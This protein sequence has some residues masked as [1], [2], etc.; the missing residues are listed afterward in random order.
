MIPSP[1]PPKN[2]KL[3]L[4]NIISGNVIA[5]KLQRRKALFTSCLENIVPSVVDCISIEIEE[6]KKYINVIPDKY[7]TKLGALRIF[8]CSLI[9]SLLLQDQISH[10]FN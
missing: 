10:V 7:K 4:S 3:R 9:T 1:N 5:A 8:C 6:N 2:C